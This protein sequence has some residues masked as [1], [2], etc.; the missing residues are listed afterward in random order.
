MVALATA[1]GGGAEIGVNEMSEM[2]SSGLRASR[3]TTED[4]RRIKLGLRRKGRVPGKS[5]GRCFGVTA[6]TARTW[7]HTTT[8]HHR[9]QPKNQ[10]GAEGKLGEGWKSSTEVL[11]ASKASK[12]GPPAG[13]P[14]LSRSQIGFISNAR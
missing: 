13:P 10:A 2:T 1:G 3:L 14:Q 7:I 5:S 6:V 8:A 9:R 12:K 11:R 4:S